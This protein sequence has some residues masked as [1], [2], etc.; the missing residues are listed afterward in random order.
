MKR[1]WKSISHL[2]WRWQVAFYSAMLWLMEYGY[3]IGR[4]TGRNPV[5]LAAESNDISSIS[6]HLAR[7]LINEDAPL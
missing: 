4:D 1:L 2:L 3:V 7:L 5:A 6:G